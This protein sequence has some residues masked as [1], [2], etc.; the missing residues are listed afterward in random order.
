MLTPHPLLDRGG[1][2]ARCDANNH[3]SGA[4]TDP[5]APLHLALTGQSIPPSRVGVAG[6]FTKNTPL[7]SCRPSTQADQTGVVS[8]A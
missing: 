8:R 6:A 2:F 4:H 5:D 3:K 7:R 1:G